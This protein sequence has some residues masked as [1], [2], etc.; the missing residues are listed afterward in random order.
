MST[1][2]KTDGQ[3][4]VAF[5]QGLNALP[6]KMRK[7]LTVMEGTV[8]ALVAEAYTRGFDDGAEAERKK[9]AA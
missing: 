8:K 5:F 6:E 7:T 3:R 9:A 1:D 4:N 2:A